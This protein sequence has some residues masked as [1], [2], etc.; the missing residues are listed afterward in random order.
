MVVMLKFKNDPNPS[1]DDWH[2][3]HPM[4]E[5]LHARTWPTV[6]ELQEF[7]HPLTARTVWQMMRGDV[8]SG[9][10]YRGTASEDRTMREA[11]SEGKRRSHNR[12]VKDCA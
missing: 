7:L 10:S 9:A 2:E 3:T 1:T 4:E 6:E 12:R 8:Y 11:I 5:G